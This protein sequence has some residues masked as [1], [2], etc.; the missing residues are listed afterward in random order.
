[1]V[2]TP[3]WTAELSAPARTL[4]VRDIDGDGRLDIVALTDDGRLPAWDALGNPIAS[5][6]TAPAPMSTALD[7]RYSYT[8]STA[9]DINGKSPDIITAT[10]IACEG[11]HEVARL[12]RRML[13]PG[14]AQVSGLDAWPGPDENSILLGDDEGLTWWRIG[15]QSL[16]FATRGRPIFA[17]I[18]RLIPDAPIVAVALVDRQIKVFGA[19]L[20]AVREGVLWRAPRPANEVQTSLEEDGP[21]ELNKTGRQW[22]VFGSGETVYLIR[23]DGQV[24]SVRAPGPVTHTVPG[25]AQSRSHGGWIHVVR[26][27]A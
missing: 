25:D 5:P 20:D 17:W 27:G 14:G 15:A 4:V 19:S 11:N 21:Y 9:S 18:G 13:Q 1:M 26:P 3:Y 23:N 2:T 6:Y 16:R 10:I 12:T 8:L 24:T 22:W 7:G